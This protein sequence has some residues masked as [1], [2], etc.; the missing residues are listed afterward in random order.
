MEGVLGDVGDL[1]ESAVLRRVKA[2]NSSFSEM[3]WRR[4]DRRRDGEDDML[5]ASLISVGAR[6]EMSVSASESVPDEDASLMDD[7][8]DEGRNAISSDG[9]RKVCCAEDDGF[10]VEA[11]ILRGLINRRN[12]L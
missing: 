8:D 3:E 2:S 7:A 12:E 11:L 6:V 10:W 1:S 9:E 4:G 5:D